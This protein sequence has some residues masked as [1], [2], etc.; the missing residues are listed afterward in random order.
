[1]N[2]VLGFDPNKGEIDVEAGIRWPALI[3]YLVASARATSSGGSSRSRRAPIVSASAGPGANVHGR[4]LRMKP[5]IADVE[6]FVLLDAA[7]FPEDVTV[8]RTELF[9][10]AIGGYG[11]LGVI[12]SV[13]LRLAP[14]GSCGAWCCSRWRT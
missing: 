5:F 14:G 12:A 13:R 9:R 10:L 11:L 8:A 2:R 1:M 4:G 3:D 7:G 6:S